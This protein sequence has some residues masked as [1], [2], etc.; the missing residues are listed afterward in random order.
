MAGR[1]R[2]KREQGSPCSQ[3]LNGRRRCNAPVL[4]CRIPGQA[5]G[6]FLTGRPGLFVWSIWSIW[7]DGLDDR[8]RLRERLIR[9]GP[10]IG[11]VGCHEAGED[12]F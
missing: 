4:A 5:L 9:S 8:V 2:G 11:P 6:R 12:G 7:R 1:R 10:I 3:S